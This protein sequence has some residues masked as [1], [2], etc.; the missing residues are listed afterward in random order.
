M[1]PAQSNSEYLLRRTYTNTRIPACIQH[2]TPSDLKTPAAINPWGRSAAPTPRS[3]SRRAPL[4]LQAGCLTL[5]SLDFG[6]RLSAQPDYRIAA[7]AGELLCRPCSRGRDCEA[8]TLGAVCV[9][10]CRPVSASAP[11]R[12]GLLSSPS[13]PASPGQP[14]RAAHPGRPSTAR[15]SHAPGRPAQSVG[16]R[17]ARRQRSPRTPEE[18]RCR[19]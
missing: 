16:Q 12:P 8:H 3:P 1:Q 7:Y 13:A 19:P 11:H 2:N 17:Q 4:P 9:V 5:A 18:F 10:V 14:S 6:N 15:S